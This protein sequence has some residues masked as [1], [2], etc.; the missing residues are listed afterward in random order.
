[1]DARA[2]VRYVPHNAVYDRRRAKDDLSALNNARARSAAT[3]SH[4]SSQDVGDHIGA[5]ANGKKES[6]GDE[7]IFGPYRRQVGLQE[8]IEFLHWTDLANG[9]T[10]W[11][12]SNKV[13]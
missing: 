1:M 7:K 8:F 13:I 9:H 12:F 5:G 2:V 11:R 10:T 3:V 6:S 4:D